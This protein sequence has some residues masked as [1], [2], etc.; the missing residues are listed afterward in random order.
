MPAR[1]SE[2]IVAALATPILLVV[3]FI[4]LFFVW[5]GAATVAEVPDPSVPDGDPCCTYPDTWGEIAG[6]A[7][8]TLVFALVAGLALWAVAAMVPF[9][10]RGRW[11]RVG[12]LLLIPLVVVL[13]TA[14]V[15][16]ALVIPNLA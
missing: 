7:A 9:A 6:G 11:P 5:W 12:R 1:R 15:E 3:A 4:A 13:G 8:F 10:A 14:A 2:R 16:V